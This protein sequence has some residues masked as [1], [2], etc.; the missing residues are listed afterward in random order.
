MSSTFRF[1][2]G[3][4]DSSTSIGVDVSLTIFASSFSLVTPSSFVAVSVLDDCFSPLPFPSCTIGVDVEVVD[5]TGLS[6]TIIASTVDVTVWSSSV[7]ITS[8]SFAVVVGLASTD[9]F[10]TSVGGITASST[11]RFASGGSSIVRSS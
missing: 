6:C 1:N 10:S 2:D 4:C 5:R 3:V 7:L 11:P 9:S 8:L